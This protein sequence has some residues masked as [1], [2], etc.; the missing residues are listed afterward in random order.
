VTVP[1]SWI[2]GPDDNYA[3][4]AHGLGS[5]AVQVSLTSAGTFFLAPWLVLDENRVEIHVSHSFTG[6]ASAMISGLL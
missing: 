5:T 1:L 6:A 4:A 2:S 3:I